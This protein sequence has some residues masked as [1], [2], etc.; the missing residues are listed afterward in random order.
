M[1]DVLKVAES[2]RR[3]EFV[4]TWFCDGEEGGSIGDRG[5][6]AGKG[7]E[8]T[9]REVWET[10]IAERIAAETA[11][12]RIG[13]LEYYWES[14]KAAATALRTIKEAWKHR[15]RPLPEWARQAIAAGWKAPK[16]WKP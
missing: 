16:G 2:R 8:P 6:K 14:H 7:Q 11:S 5:E 9:D 10:W 4:L 3:D 15:E 13:R 12:G 1:S